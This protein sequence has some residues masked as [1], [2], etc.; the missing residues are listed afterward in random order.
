MSG[1]KRNGAEPASIC[2]LL[3]YA[4]VEKTR[5]FRVFA[6]RTYV[7]ADFTAREAQIFRLEADASGRPRIA[8]ERRAAPEEEPLRRQ[9]EAGH[10]LGFVVLALKAQ[11]QS[12]IL[13][14]A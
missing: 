7:S 3:P 9:I 13:V 8:S 12:Q 11:H 4:S 5:K 10:A 1:L 6:P 14:H 2:A